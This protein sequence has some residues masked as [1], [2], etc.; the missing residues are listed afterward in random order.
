M[1]TAG[2]R[3]RAKVAGT[4]DYY[5]QLRSEQAA[6]R[7]DVAIVVCDASEGLTSEDLRVAEMA[8]QKHCAT[9]IAL[10]KWDVTRTDLEDAKARVTQKLRQ[11]PPVLAVSA[12]SGRG[13]TRLIAAAL[14]RVDRSGEQIQTAQ[15]NRFLSDIQSAKQ[16][17]A[18]RGKRLRMYYMAQF[19]SGP[20][21]FAVQV[22][23][24]EP[25]DPLVRLFPREPAARPVGARRR[26]AHH[27]LQ[28]A[29]T[30]GDRRR[31]VRP[32]RGAARVRAGLEPGEG[33][34]G[35]TSAAAAGAS[36]R[37]AT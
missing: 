11:R 12:S 19:E 37:R 3:R 10:N 27:R 7:A 1:D 8:M 23:D 36:G 15:L 18:K 35:A 25:R 30:A 14:A 28:G 20:P 34:A 24:R 5:A 4:V 6:E 29:R 33:G 32:R 2:L 31:G 9:V 17:P 13:L 21:R 16:P 26:A 22:N